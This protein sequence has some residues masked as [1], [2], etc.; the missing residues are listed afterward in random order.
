MQITAEV[1]SR[2]K[3]DSLVVTLAPPPEEIRARMV[4]GSDVTL[5][6]GFARAI[7]HE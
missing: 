1:L 7:W 4:F 6:D 3:S 2:S 5:Q